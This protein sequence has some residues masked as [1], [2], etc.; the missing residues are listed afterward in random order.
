M[1]L[2]KLTFIFIF[3]RLYFRPGDSELDEFYPRAS[4][5]LHISNLS[6]EA[7]ESDLREKFSNCGKILKIDIKRNQNFGTV[8]FADVSSVVK[9]IKSFDG[10]TFVADQ[11]LRLSFGRS[12]PTKC[13]WCK[14]ISE[15]V[16]QNQIYH[17]FGRYGKV[18]DC[19]I[20]RSRG[21]AL[22]YFDQVIFKTKHLFYFRNRRCA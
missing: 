13:V 4:R 21:H 8:Q 22:I 9:A 11:K 15:Q 3:R 2:I 12:I 7:A 16:S 6:R 14:G 18:Q 5:I 10:E 20:D 17:E 1:D 19:V